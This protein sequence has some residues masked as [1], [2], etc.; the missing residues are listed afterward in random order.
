MARA[1]RMKRIRVPQIGT[2]IVAALNQTS[3]LL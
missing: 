3:L 2:A 1:M